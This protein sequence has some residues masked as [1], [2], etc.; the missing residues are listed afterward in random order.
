MVVEGMY[1]NTEDVPLLIQPASIDSLEPAYPCPAASALFRSYGVGSTNANWTA[2][3]RASAPL[4][5]QLDSISGVLPSDTGFHQSCTLPFKITPQSPFPSQNQ[6]CTIQKLTPSFSTY[7]GPLLRQ[8]LLPPLPRKAPPLHHRQP[9]ILRHRR[10]RQR[11]LP[12]RPVRILVHLPRRPAKSAGERR[13]LCVECIPF[14]PP[15]SQSMPFPQVLTG[16]IDGV[17]IAELSAHIHA[18][19]TR[20]SP[21]LYRHNVAHDGSISRLLSILQVD[22]MV[23]PGM[24]SEIVFELYSRD[25]EWFVRILWG[26]RV[27]R[28]SSP[29]L[30]LVDMVSVQRILAYL[31]GLVGRD[32]ER[33]KG[34]CRG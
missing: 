2:H 28:S 20:S 19:T 7:R 26:G 13:F 11:R 1:K 30:G 24:G 8:P 15:L 6:L 29:V 23:W 22:V 32:A 3:L 25:D 16:G 33:V 34:L 4:Y 27:L 10:Q 31:E 21:V 14:S 12:P 18:A 5:E 9:N 17:F